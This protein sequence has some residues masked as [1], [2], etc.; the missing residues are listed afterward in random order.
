MSFSIFRCYELQCSHRLTKVPAD[1]KCAAMHGHNFEIEIHI[2]DQGRPP[3]PFDEALNAQG[4]VADYSLIDEAWAP[5]FK[6]LDHKTLNNVLDNPTS[7]MIAFYI[8]REVQNDLKRIGRA[9]GVTGLRVSHV[10]V[11]EN[12]RSGAVYWGDD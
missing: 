4:M 10:V 6:Q 12:K 2:E 5:T 3:F 1:H 8:F 11:R 7:E 9:A